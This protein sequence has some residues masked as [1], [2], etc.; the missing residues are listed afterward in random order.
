LYIGDLFGKIFSLVGSG[1]EAFGTTVTKRKGWSKSSEKVKY[2][3]IIKKITTHLVKL[4]CCLHYPMKCLPLK[5]D[6]NFT[7]KLT[8]SSELPESAVRRFQCGK[9]D[10]MC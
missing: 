3:L 2:C 9:C 5:G 8:L 6:K 10:H 4:R 7:L 1:K